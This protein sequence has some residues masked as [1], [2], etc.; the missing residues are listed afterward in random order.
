[1]PTL[2]PI[3]RQ[4]TDREKRLLRFAAARQRRFLRRLGP[5]VVLV[6]GVV[7]F[8]GLWGFTILAT[9]ADKTGPSWRT[10]GLIWLAI[11]IPISLWSYFRNL[12]PHFARSEGTFDG[13]LRRDQAVAVRIRA[14]AVVEI[15]GGKNENPVFAFQVGEKTIAFVDLP[16]SRLPA[17]FPAADF[18]LVDLVAENGRFVFSL[19][20]PAGSKIS[21]VRRIS[22]SERRKLTIPAHLETAHGELNQ[23]DSLLG[24]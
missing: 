10:S 24:A 8:G 2:K 15:A 5:L 21:P 1:M 14:S 3:V 17:R 11:G 6:V 9:R 16:R 12:K 20:E 19:V 4:L 7:L 18:W 23:L 22:A 13:A